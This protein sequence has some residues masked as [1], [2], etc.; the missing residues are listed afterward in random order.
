MGAGP[1][2]PSGW[3][4]GGGARPSDAGPTPAA[5]QSGGAVG[6]ATVARG[7][8]RRAAGRAGSRGGAA[9]R[10]RAGGRRRARRRA[11]HVGPVVRAGVTKKEIENR[12]EDS[13]RGGGNG[14][15][16]GAV[17]PRT[18]RGATSGGGAPA[19]V[20]AR[21]FT[22]ADVDRQ[23]PRDAACVAKRGGHGPRQAA[24]KKNQSAADPRTMRR[25]ATNRP[26]A[27]TRVGTA[28]TRATDTL[29]RIAHVPNVQA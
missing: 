16:L 22:A 27:S 7:A 1:R 17:R 14:D 21:P 25:I 4:A 24:K 8:T 23:H 20:A 29:A 18:R 6:T 11:P 2:P 9:R 3:E 12:H 19:G 5:G 13:R 15:P 10:R 26:G 28:Y